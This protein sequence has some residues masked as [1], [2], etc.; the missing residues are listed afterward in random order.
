MAQDRGCSMIV[1]GRGEK[2]SQRI[3]LKRNLQRTDARG[4][5]SSKIK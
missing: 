3:E 4:A 2:K 1:A 5:V